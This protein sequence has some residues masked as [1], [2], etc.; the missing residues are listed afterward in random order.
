MTTTART[1]PSDVKD[2][3]LAAEGRRRTEW[4]GALSGAGR[5]GVVACGRGATEE[6]A[7]GVIRLKAMARD[8]V[9]QFP[10]IAVNDS[11]TKHMF[12]N[13]YGTGQS[14]LDGI[15]RA[16]NLLVAGST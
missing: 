1:A 11:D 5:Q 12:Y 13:R 4:A 9:R 3:S 8:A 10:V 6:T 7:T 16:T 2:L 15:L 14:T